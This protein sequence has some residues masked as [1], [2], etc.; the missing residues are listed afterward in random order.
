MSWFYCLFVLATFASII[1]G[2]EYLS[3]LKLAN[4]FSPLSSDDIKNTENLAAN[5]PYLSCPVGWTGRFC[6][7][8]ICTNKSTPYIPTDTSSILIDKMNFQ[9]G[10]VGS[11]EFP[12]DGSMKYVMITAHSDQGSPIINLTDSSGNTIQTTSTYNSPGQGV[13]SFA[14]LIPGT[15]SVTVNNGNTPTTFCIVSINS[16]SELIVSGGFVS[17]PN[18]DTPHDGISGVSEYFVV[19]PLN[20]PS[21]GFIGSVKIRKNGNYIPDWV[22]ALTTRFGCGYSYYAG[23]YTCNE[24][25]NEFMYTVDGIDSNGYPFRRSNTFTCLKP[26]NPPPTP[27]TL[28]PQPTQCYNGG[29]I[30]GNTTSSVYCICPEL[31]TGQTCQTVSCVNGGISINSGTA[32]DCPPGFSGLNCQDVV[33]SDAHKT[34]FGTDYKSLIVVVRLSQSIKNRIPLIISSMQMNDLI[35]SLDNKDVYHSFVLV[36]VT[37][38]NIMSKN[39][40]R[41]INDFYSYFNSLQNSSLIANGCT[42]TIVGG[43]ESIFDT[44]LIYNKSP[45]YV[46]TDV[47]SSPDEN[48][49]SVMH[50]NTARKFP[51]HI[52]MVLDESNQCGF[53]P[54]NSGFEVFETISRRSG[55]LTY[56][57]PLNDFVHFFQWIQSSTAFQMNMA[58]FGDYK[59][60]LMKGF[61][62][63]FVDNTEKSVFILATGTNLSL[64]ITRPDF[65]TVNP[66]L[67][68]HNGDS[69]IWEIFNDNLMIGEYLILLSSVGGATYPCNYRVMTQSNYELFLGVSNEITNDVTFFDPIYEKPSHLVAQIGG[70]QDNIYDPF[71]LFAEMTIY[72]YDKFGNIIPVYFSNGI[73]RDQCD[74][75]LYFNS[76]TCRVPDQELMITV[77]ADDNNG[78]TIQRS[79]PAVCADIEL[80]PAP[81]GTC[82][83]GGVQNPY[84]SSQCI[85]Q[86]NWSGRYC[87]QINCQ[88]NG[89]QVNGRCSC[90]NGTGGRFCEKIKCND[91]STNV[92]FVNEERSLIF[93]INIEYTM[94]HAVNE[95]NTKLPDM[96]R[97]LQGIS[98]TFI[99]QYILIAYN[100]TYNVGQY[101]GSDAVEF[102]TAFNNVA[103]MPLLSDPNANCNGQLMEALSL[104]GLYNQKNQPLIFVFSDSDY[105]NSDFAQQSYNNI[106]INLESLQ[107]TIN[108][109]IPSTQ[110]CNNGT[111]TTTLSDDLKSLIEFTNGDVSFTVTPGN[112]LDY[113]STL[114]ESGRF[115]AFYSFD[116]NLNPITY[117]L[118]IDQWS[119]SFTVSAHGSNLKINVYDPYGNDASGDYL[120][121]ILSDNTNMINQYIIPCDSKRDIPRNQYCYNLQ[122][123]RLS[124]D[125]AQVA[126]HQTKGSFLFDLFSPQ[127]ETFFDNQIGTIGVWMG[128]RRGIDNVWR[129]DAPDGVQRQP[130][131]S[132]SNWASQPIDNDG[133]DCAYMM[134]DTTGQ[135]KWYRDTCNKT[136]NFIC[137]RH[138]YGQVISPDVDSANLLPAGIWKMK[139]SGTGQCYFNSMVQSKIQVFYG[140]VNDIH[141]DIPS[142]IANLG[143]TTNRFI[144]TATGLEPINTESFVNNIDG[145]LNYAFM[146]KTAL[147]STKPAVMLT[148]VTFQ[149]R[150]ECSYRTVSQTFT[151]PDKDSNLASH[152]Y[153]VKFSGIDQFGNL[154]ERLSTS[155]CAKPITKCLNGGYIYNGQCICPPNYTGSRCGTILCFNGGQINEDGTCT[156]QQ[157]FSGVSCETPMCELKHPQNFA[158]DHKTLAI[159]IEQSYGSTSMIK[160]LIATLKDTIKKM[161]Q[162]KQALWFS[163]YIL[164]PFD[165]TKNSGVWAPVVAS[166]NINDIIN[167]LKNI[168]SGQCADNMPCPS[169]N[170]CNRPIF[171][172]MNYLLSRDDFNKPN[173][174]VLLFTRSGVED[175][176]YYDL[177]TQIQQVKPV[178]NVI[179]VD[180]VSPCSLGFETMEAR[181]LMRLA[182]ATGGNLY[183]MTSRQA[184]T[185]LLQS[186]F[187]T[188]YTTNLIEGQN[189]VR[190]CSNDEALFQIDSDASEFTISYVGGFDAKL[191]LYGPDQTVIDL[192]TPVVLSDTNRIYVIQTNAS[193]KVQTGTYRL[194]S[195][196]STQFCNIHVHVNSPLEVFTGYAVVTDNLNG[197]TQDDGYFAPVAKIGAKNIMMFHANNLENGFLTFVQLYS[198]R[199]LFFTSEIKKRESCSYEYY[200]T[201]TFECMFENFEVAVYGV[202]NNGNNFR[203][204][205][206][207]SCINEMP[208]RDPPPPFCDLSLVKQDFLFIMDTSVNQYF[209]NLKSTAIG[210]VGKYYVQG[211]N[212]TRVGGISVADQSSLNFNLS[213]TTTSN[214]LFG[215]FNTFQQSNSTGQNLA[216]AFTIAGSIASNPTSGYRTDNDIHHTIV[217]LTSNDKYTGDDALQIFNN[218]KRSGSWG[219]LTVGLNVPYKAP[220]EVLN[221]NKCMYVTNDPNKFQ[222]NAVNFVQSHSCRR[223]SICGE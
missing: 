106:L 156:C 147:N 222:T 162:G 163:N 113:I 67:N 142:N 150:E 12:V 4:V 46:I 56:Q 158:N 91:K 178:I 6:E 132:Y 182:G 81:P 218:L 59:N 216:S 33:C 1:N 15:F 121:Q 154:F 60:C 101:I 20:I 22:A 140:F 207:G 11:I 185:N 111:R 45:V 159:V 36:T 136:Y 102:L 87:E 52:F 9:S 204:V 82:Q 107:S 73:Y 172:V 143:S 53:D 145:N 64:T 40:F 99:T 30:I 55:G 3:R 25:D 193:S 190:N 51:I 32:C 180:A 83:N 93:I 62:T 175:Y 39:D 126:C 168:P 14:N 138:K 211:L 7:S 57:L 187:P 146:Y 104:A 84:N 166:S 200:S 127:K 109:I 120:N 42:D 26:I 37:D 223:F 29:T 79:I 184:A 76:F 5:G 61:T 210:I 191:K 105:L 65:K 152:E 13:S 48:H 167:G 77:Y 86:Q 160:Y 131:G 188:L 88:N 148:P 49:I 169:G 78:N 38:S 43:I 103:K 69:Y 176:D 124:W 153:F 63:F 23:M 80:T 115:G 116:C 141:E 54:M 66:V 208:E 125:D 205:T 217:Y 92:T 18:Y 177:F 198:E 70:L 155:I 28:P 74:Y 108:L 112:Y 165:Q 27:T 10:C 21:P 170:S 161:S 215:Y 183:V 118:P 149:R 123:S 24:M 212:N 195:Q 2:D 137:Q 196:T 130:L 201:Q 135:S 202:D 174:Q 35:W 85:C 58:L 75:Q 17:S 19:Q 97:D 151:C 219:L 221:G 213:Q 192:P 199:G 89:I 95:L 181:G 139:I 209:S 110:I 203:R 119:Q 90:P 179:L 96:I 206:T 117:Y 194:Y 214:G 50:R 173:S 71:R 134:K 189:Y 72:S 47:I 122:T 41:D 133:L 144:A 94:Q 100:S 31:Y 68:A 186:Y 157:E 129:W 34:G 16:A 128:L 8:P 98:S 114:H 171:R 164:V 220:V 44:Q 197:V